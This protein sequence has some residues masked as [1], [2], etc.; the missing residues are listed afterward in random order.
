MHLIQEIRDEAHRFAITGHRGRRA[1]TRTRSELEEIPGL[2]AT[3]RQKLL[4][5]F[6][7]VR[8]VGRASVDELRAVEGI[9][10]ALAQRIY[11]HFHG[12]NQR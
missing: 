3:R 8:R 2:G 7:G 11:A 12:D 10:V 1:K 5:A 4:K 9:S 6:G